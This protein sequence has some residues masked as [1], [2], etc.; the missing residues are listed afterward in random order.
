MV[1]A[2]LVELQQ[3]AP[4]ALDLLPLPQIDSDQWVNLAMQYTTQWKQ[5]MKRFLQ[6]KKWSR[7]K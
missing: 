4:P 1:F 3:L 6:N 7:Y 5:L 2:D